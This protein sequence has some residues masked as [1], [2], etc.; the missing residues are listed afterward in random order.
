MS[1][2]INEI[3]FALTDAKVEFVVGGGV[4]LM[5]NPFF[6]EIKN[7]LPGCCVNSRCQEIPLVMARYGADAGVAGAGALCARGNNTPGE[8]TLIRC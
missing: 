4:A 7:Q 5:L 6:D 2:H 8:A 3:L 1:N